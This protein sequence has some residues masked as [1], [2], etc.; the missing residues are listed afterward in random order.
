M[1]HISNFPRELQFVKDFSE[2]HLPKLTGMLV[3][4]LPGKGSILISFMSQVQHQ[5][6]R[7]FLAFKKFHH[8]VCIHSLTSAKQRVVI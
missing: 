1:T 2:K 5:F 6:K 7:F 8:E 3:P 4:Y